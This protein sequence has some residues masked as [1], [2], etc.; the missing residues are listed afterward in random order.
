MHFSYLY[1][2]M[3][4]SLHSYVF[5]FNFRKIQERS[6]QLTLQSEYCATALTDVTYWI[7]AAITK[8]TLKLT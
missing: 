5:L 3:E 1:A 4:P 8:F 6:S 2:A 7:E